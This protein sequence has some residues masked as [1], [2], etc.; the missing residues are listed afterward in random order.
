M[1]FR[2]FRH[3]KQYKFEGKRTVE[4]FTAFATGGYESAQAAEVASVPTLAGR[5]KSVWNEITGDI[6]VRP[7]DPAII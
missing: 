6:G 5:A 7:L 2:S 1:D 3:G 4:A